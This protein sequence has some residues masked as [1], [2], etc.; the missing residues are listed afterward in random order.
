MTSAEEGERRTD[1]ISVAQTLKRAKV[2]DTKQKLLLLYVVYHGVL[3]EYETGG[4]PYARSNMIE[5]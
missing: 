3:E 1:E 4:N 5:G 2:V